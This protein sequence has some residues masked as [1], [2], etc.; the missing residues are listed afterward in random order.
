MNE[1]EIIVSGG[2]YMLILY[3]EKIETNY[4]TLRT[5]ENISWPF[6]TANFSLVQTFDHAY[7]CS[8]DFGSAFGDT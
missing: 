5:Y 8:Y 7:L 3:R 2:G 1:K 4:G 6:L